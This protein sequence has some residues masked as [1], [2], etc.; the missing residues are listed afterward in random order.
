MAT[1]AI[2]T[3]I[4]HCFVVFED[5]KMVSQSRF[6]TVTHKQLG[7]KSSLLV[8]YLEILV[9]GTCIFKQLAVL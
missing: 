2:M 7:T 4:L 3:L 1:D 6:M 5:Q 8:N 9:F